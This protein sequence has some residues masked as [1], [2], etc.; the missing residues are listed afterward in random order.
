M[1]TTP[2]K[3]VFRSA[4]P[5]SVFVEVEDEQGNSLSPEAFDGVVTSEDAEG[6]WSITLSAAVEPAPAGHPDEVVERAAWELWRAAGSPDGV[7]KRDPY[8]KQARALAAAGLLA[9]P[10]GV[11]HWTVILVD[12]RLKSVPVEVADGW[13]L[14][15]WL[16]AEAVWLLG[17]YQRDVVTNWKPRFD[18]ARIDKALALLDDTEPCVCGDCAHPCRGH[19][20]V[21]AALTGGAG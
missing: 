12:G 4:G 21:R 11:G 20:A 1:S 9:D 7:A 5:D 3:F 17:Q 15:S 10:G 19:D 13:T 14:L 18:D 2:I 8:R 6:F 16:H